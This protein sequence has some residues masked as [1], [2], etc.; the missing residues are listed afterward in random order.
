[1]AGRLFVAATVAFAVG[2]VAVGLYDVRLTSYLG[3]PQ[4]Y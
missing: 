2:C 3:P 1:M 4:I